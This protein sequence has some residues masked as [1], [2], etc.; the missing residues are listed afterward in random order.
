MTFFVL[1]KARR[2]KKNNSN[3]ISV[4]THWTSESETIQQFTHNPLIKRPLLKPIQ[5]LSV[6]KR[7]IIYPRLSNCM[8]HNNEIR[9][10]EFIMGLKQSTACIQLTLSP[11][12]E[13]KIISS[14]WKAGRFDVTHDT[15]EAQK[16]F[17]LNPFFISSVIQGKFLNI[18]L[19]LLVMAG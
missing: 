15:A 10:K 12:Q 3:T 19:K 5:Y 2:C 8:A 18:W 16:I 1:D 14:I 9:I 11:A 17:L 13:I 6:F 7:W 4:K